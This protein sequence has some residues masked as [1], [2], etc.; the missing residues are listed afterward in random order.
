MADA[1]GAA[2]VRANISDL[3]IPL[4]QRGDHLRV[5]QRGGVANLVGLVLVF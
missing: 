1:R 3:L 2:S 4:D 5:G